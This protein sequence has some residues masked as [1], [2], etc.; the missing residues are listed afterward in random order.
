MCRLDTIISET[1]AETDG[2]QIDFFVLS[3]SIKQ[4]N[5]NNTDKSQTTAYKYEEAD[6]SARVIIALSLR[7]N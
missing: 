2:T 4:T 5:K 1:E 3:Q 7:F 6:R